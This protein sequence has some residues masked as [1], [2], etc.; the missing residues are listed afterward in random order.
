VTLLLVIV[1][2]YALYVMLSVLPQ[3]LAAQVQ[4]RPR[5]A[6]RSPTAQRA[7]AT[8][9]TSNVGS[10]NGTER[11]AVIGNRRESR[12]DRKRRGK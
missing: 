8:P 3:R 12:R 7:A 9:R 11:P 1:A 6:P 2:A 5:N 10:P 4:S